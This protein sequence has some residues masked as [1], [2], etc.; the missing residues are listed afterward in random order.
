MSA[1]CSFPFITVR[2]AD[3]VVGMMEINLCIE[4]GFPWRIQE[5]G[6]QGKW[7]TIL[8][9]NLVETTVVDAKT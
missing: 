7:V 3:K 9:G 2:D 4:S 6:Y 8:L 5:V 1:E